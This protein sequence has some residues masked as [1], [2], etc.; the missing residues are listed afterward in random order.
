MNLNTPIAWV[1]QHRRKLTLWAGGLFI[2]GILFSTLVLPGIIKSQ[3]EKAIVLNTGRTASIDAVRFNPFGMTLTVRGFK[4]FEADGKT[5]FAQ[6]KQLQ[7]SLSGTTLFRFAPVVDKVTL[8]TLQLHVI[9]SAANR[10]NFSDILDRLA[11]QPKKPKTTTP[12]FSI[13]NI[14][15][16]SGSIDFDDQAVS[17]SKK[18][19]VRDL[20]IAIPF[21]STIPYLAEQYTDPKFSAEVNG[22]RFSFNGKAKPLAKAIEAN[23]QLKLTDLDLPHYLA[24]L[25]A[26]IPVKLDSGKLTLDLDLTYRIHKNNQP[27][28]FIKGLTRLDQISIKEKNGAALASFKRFDVTA[29]EIELFNRKVALQQI[30]LDGLDLHADR[31]SSGKLNFQRLLPTP[32]NQAAKPA[33][34]P[35]KKETA[36][37]LQLVLDNLAL[38]N[39]TL[40]FTDKQPVGGFKAKLQ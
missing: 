32:Q 29:R 37:P 8:D 11:A 33:D 14:V 16:Q 38:T 39:G 18:H 36:P 22:A 27:E 23:L 3:A 20:Q 35:L 24:Y 26:H 4:L 12:R 5:T 19:T 13:N 31:D 10:Y 9:R 25:P 30:A 21:I 28:L 2:F 17:G 15:I 6:F 40:Q 1:K 34:K 7:V